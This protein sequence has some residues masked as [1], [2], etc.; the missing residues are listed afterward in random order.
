MR[1]DKY[2]DMRHRGPSFQEDPQRKPTRL[3]HH[4]HHH[5]EQDQPPPP[6]RPTSSPDSVLDRLSPVHFATPSRTDEIV[7]NHTKKPSFAA[8]H[9]NAAAAGAA[10]KLYTPANLSR[11]MSVNRKATWRTA[12]AEALSTPLV[13]L[14]QI[15]P[16]LQSCF[17]AETGL[18]TVQVGVEI[19]SIM[20]V[21]IEED[22]VVLTYCL[23]LDWLDL[24]TMKAYRDSKKIPDFFSSPRHYPFDP[25]FKVRHAIDHSE[26][27]NAHGC[28]ARSSMGGGSGGGRDFPVTLFY[29]RYALGLEGN[30]CSH[31]LVQLSRASRGTV[32]LRQRFD[33]ASFPLDEHVLALEFEP[34][35]LAKESVRSLIEERRLSPLGASTNAHSPNVPLTFGKRPLRL[36][37]LK[38]FEVEKCRVCGIC[39]FS[40]PYPFMANSACSKFKDFR[41]DCRLRDTVEADRYLVH[42]VS[43]YCFEHLFILSNLTT[44]VIYLS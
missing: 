12:P 34:V 24:L 13:R 8:K 29:G 7:D 38:Q 40:T 14:L 17:C 16:E 19:E 22:Y 1:R 25:R 18:P 4:H 35:S 33:I 31:T 36:K 15:I 20:E 44:D 26:A 5:Q 23:G 27:V 32:K 21:N 42:T 37:E 41:F 30:G 28:S 11:F 9:H 10:T 43:F 39:C 3:Y 2:N 6:P